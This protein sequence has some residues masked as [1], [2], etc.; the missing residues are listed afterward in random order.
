MA[1][2]LLECVPNFSE[3]KDRE[4]INGLRHAV[5]YVEGVQLLH[6]DC[7]EAAHRAVFTF[8]GEPDA[9]VEAAFQAIKKA[10]ETIDMGLH[11]GEHPRMGATDVC[12]LIPLQN[13]TISEADYYANKL[14][15]RVGEELQIPVYLYEQSSKSP[16]REN[17]ARV[18]KGGYE[19][20]GKKLQ[21][22]EW[23]PDY[24][25]STLPEKAGVTAIGAR[26]F[27]IAFNINLNT[28]KAAKAHKV[29]CDVRESGH[30]LR[31]DHGNLL[32]DES[33][34]VKR[35]PG[36]LKKV[37]GIGWYIEEF[38]LAQISMNVTDINASPL[39]MVFETVIEKADQRGLR[40]TG[41]EI[42][43]MVPKRVLLEAGRHFL[44]K[45][46]EDPECYRENEIL[47]MAVL[48]LEL[49]DVVSF[50]PQEKVIESQ[51]NWV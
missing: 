14:A 48:S 4:V 3:G 2:K 6:I 19:G 20:M 47:D 41:S 12:P 10:S 49:N 8:A 17:L 16:E 31:D 25:P 32:R 27:L 28:K 30:P 11:K 40:V 45:Q 33:G 24:G 5:E 9:V 50:D 51:L 15:K 46:A 43:G 37:K 1:N 35:L 22:P 18:R 42:V 26:D 7:G 13:M 23:Q 38:G 34:K 21:N 36:A 39:Q 44:T 29:A